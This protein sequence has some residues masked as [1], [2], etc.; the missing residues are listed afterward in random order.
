MKKILICSVVL[1]ILTLPAFGARYAERSGSGF[2]YLIK[3]RQQRAMENIRRRWGYNEVLDK[4]RMQQEEIR[5][6]KLF[7]S[8]ERNPQD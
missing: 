4:N 5:D 6:E 8:W 3:Q 1:N 2:N 7:F